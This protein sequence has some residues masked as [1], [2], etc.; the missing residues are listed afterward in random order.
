MSSF[1]RGTE[2]RGQCFADGLDDI[3]C[4]RSLFVEVPLALGRL[5]DTVYQRHRV[6]KV[7]HWL[8]HRLLCFS[9]CT[10]LAQQPQVHDCQIHARVLINRHKHTV[11]S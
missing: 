5:H 7:R 4:D 2:A 9:T 11:R 3:F 8:N 1:G 6:S 10:H